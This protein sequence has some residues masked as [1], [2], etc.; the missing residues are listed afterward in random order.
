M[1]WYED[2]QRFIRQY[3]FRTP[4]SVAHSTVLVSAGIYAFS[5]GTSPRV[6]AHLWFRLCSIPK[7]CP[8]VLQSM[9]TPKSSV[10]TFPIT[11]LIIYW[12]HCWHTAPVVLPLVT[13]SCVRRT[14]TVP[15]LPAARLELFAECKLKRV[16]RTTCVTWAICVIWAI[17]VTFYNTIQYNCTLI[18]PSFQSSEVHTRRCRRYNYIAEQL[19]AKDLLK[20]PTHVTACLG[21]GSNPYSPRYRPSA[22]NNRPPCRKLLLDL[23]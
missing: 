11:L 13:S 3:Q 1:L 12:A 16:T 8:P 7:S 23:G 17:R 6:N 15:H 10:K 14:Y 2:Q 18:L 4:E 20:V 19:W 22:L 5:V 21:R 9:F